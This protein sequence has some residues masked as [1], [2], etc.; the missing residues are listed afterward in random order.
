[1][2]NRKKGGQLGNKNAARAGEWR[3][4]LKWALKNYEDG[5]IK[6]GTALREIGTTT[7]K[8]A[9]AGD[10]DARAEIANRMDG[11]APVT[12]DVG[13]SPIEELSIDDQRAA[14]R[15]INAAI[16][17]LESNAGTDSPTIN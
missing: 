3:D 6:K 15:A 8:L 9:I 2:G 17:E 10:K 14:L 5:T 13:T 12:I 1:M 16:A 4:A 7:V 11:K